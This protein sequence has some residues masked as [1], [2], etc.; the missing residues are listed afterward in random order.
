MTEQLAARDPIELSSLTSLPLPHLSI[1]GTLPD[2][3]FGAERQP[4]PSEP[5]TTKLVTTS[6]PPNAT[7]TSTSHPTAYPGPRRPLTTTMGDLP[8][9]LIQK[10]LAEADLASVVAA[11]GV[12]SAWR[13]VVKDVSV[14]SRCSDEWCGVVC[15]SRNGFTRPKGWVGTVSECSCGQA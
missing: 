3:R 13:A 9:E 12:N 4:S 1:R 7:E 5:T 8:A 11:G 10:I 6:V 14:V 15:L 2:S